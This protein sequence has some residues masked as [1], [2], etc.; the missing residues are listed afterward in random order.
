M[1]KTKPRFI[2]IPVLHSLLIIHN[3]IIAIYYLR[4]VAL[5]LGETKS[6]VMNMLMN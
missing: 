5:R 4:K 3:K 2:I 6:N 1:M